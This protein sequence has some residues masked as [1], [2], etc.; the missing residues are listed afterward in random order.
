VGWAVARHRLFNLR[1]FVRKT[2]VYG[3]LLSLV[4]AAYSAVVL[5][6][7]VRLSEGRTSTLA[8]FAVIALAG[9]FDPLKRFLDDRIDR[10]LFSERRS[11]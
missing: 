9:A 3:I 11:K 1:V 7:T 4:A 6:L 8:Q 10:L 2:L 5:T